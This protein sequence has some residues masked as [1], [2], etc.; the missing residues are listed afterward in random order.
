MQIG[1]YILG[2]EIGRGGMG[3]VYESFHPQLARP[4]AIK[5]IQSSDA[6]SHASFM[7]EVRTVAGLSHPNIVNIFDVDEYQSQPFLV[8]E[9]FGASLAD[10]I[11]NGPLAPA[12]VIRIGLKL[13]DVLEYAHNQS[14][15]HRDIKPAN[16]LL[17][18]D[19]TPVL[20]DFGLARAVAG[21]STQKT[22]SLLGT[23]AYMAPEQFR[24]Q[25]ATVHTDLYALGVL[26]FEALTGQVPFDGTTAEIIQGHLQHPV[27][28]LRTLATNIP[29]DLET[30]VLQLLDK[31]PVQRPASAAS[32][33]Q[34]LMA[35]QGRLLPATPSAAN[36]TP[37][38]ATGPT[39]VILGTPGLAQMPPKTGR[40]NQI[41]QQARPAPMPSQP[42]KPLILG[43]IAIGAVILLAV[44][45][46]LAVPPKDTHVDV[47]IPTIQPIVRTAK[48]PGQL[49]QLA[50]RQLGQ[51][52]MVNPKPAANTSE[53][54]YSGVTWEDTANS[55][56]FYG[57]LRND[58]QTPQ[59]NVSVQITLLNSAGQM[60]SQTK[61]Q[62][63]L[64]VVKPGEITPF[65]VLFFEEEVPSTKFANYTIEVL[66]K[67]DESFALGY[68]IYDGLRV[69]VSEV[70]K[71]SLGDIPVVRGTF[72]NDRDT[73][74]N[75]PE[76][77]AVFYNEAGEVIG[78]TSC[79]ADT[80]AGTNA[81]EARSSAAFETIF[82]SL[83]QRGPTAYMLYV[84]GRKK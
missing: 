6:E 40:A 12:E 7:R 34:A 11:A 47:Q 77:V 78:V 66:S 82:F 16:V 54:S 14:I 35:I 73:A 37:A 43:F 30:L 59:A 27:P 57:E 53:F 24:H 75:F 20:A 62:V 61:S 46:R 60:I 1:K 10:R 4:V 74:I 76:V 81:L 70:G 2:R 41:H 72:Y 22:T 71:N 42:R 52:R 26:L 8:M 63:E 32:V 31:D 18:P 64:G 84:E 65:H 56:T 48:P 9:L 49:T 13:A 68:Y 39:M 5:L 67:P 45:L 50:L 79:Y 25:P 51:G 29:P 80:P 38:A 17:R 21:V 69:T 28:H 58:S 33:T 15:I 19:E 44:L 36:A 83:T 55:I 3:T 23:P